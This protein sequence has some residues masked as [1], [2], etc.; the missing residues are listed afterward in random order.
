[1]ERRKLVLENVGDE[2]VMTVKYV[3]EV[4]TKFGKKLVFADD[5]SETPLI[6]DTSADKQLARLDLDRKTVVGRTIEFSRAPNPSGK[7]FWNLSLVATAPEGKRVESPYRAPAKPSKAQPFDEPSREEKMDAA[8]AALEGEES[9]EEF[10]DAIAAV[11]KAP[12]IANQTEAAYCALYARV[13]KFQVALA[14][15]LQ[16]PVDGSSINAQ[17]FSIFKA[18]GH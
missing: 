1:M 4:T 11:G 13:A 9:F 8:M 12:S 17:T 7:P 16:F 3:N 10:S 14:A 2:A 18:Q 15:E 6:P 5:T